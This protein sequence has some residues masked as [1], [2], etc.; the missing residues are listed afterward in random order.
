MCLKIQIRN[1]EWGPR[2]ASEN[3]VCVYWAKLRSCLKSTA[4]DSNPTFSKN[5]FEMSSIVMRWVAS[6]FSTK[7]QIDKAVEI[8]GWADP[9]CLPPSRVRHSRRG[10]ISVLGHCREEFLWLKE[11]SLRGFPSPDGGSANTLWAIRRARKLLSYSV[12]AAIQFGFISRPF[13]W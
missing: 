6:W 8:L 13:I 5:Y 10:C 11:V 12:P 4:T 3:P 1:L 9:L 7:E 2:H